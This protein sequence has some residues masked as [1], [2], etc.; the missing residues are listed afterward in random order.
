MR[1]EHWAKDTGSV[2]STFSENEASHALQERFLRSQ[3]WREHESFHEKRGEHA[4]LVV[5]RE[6]DEPTPME[7]MKE[8]VAPD[9][10]H[11]T[12]R[13]VMTGW[14]QCQS[15]SVRLL[16]GDDGDVKNE[17]QS[18]IETNSYGVVAD[19]TSNYGSSSGG[20]PLYLPAAPV[21]VN[22]KP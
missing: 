17:P 5:H 3:A 11:G 18:P 21:N 12:R 15:P 16:L 2:D 20:T 8:E 4:V 10:Q 22:Y 19:D 7:R 6:E 9:Q 13:A 14:C 1:I